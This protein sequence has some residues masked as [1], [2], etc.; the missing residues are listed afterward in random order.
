MVPRAGRLRLP[1]KVPAGHLLRLGAD[2]GTGKIEISAQHVHG[3]GT[4]A[5]A[6]IISI[7]LKNNES[8]RIEQTAILCGDGQVIYGTDD[9]EDAIAANS[10]LQDK[11]LELWK[12]SLHPEFEHLDEVIHVRKTLFAENDRGAIQDF[13]SDQLRCIVRDVRERFK[14]SSLN[15]GEDAEYWDNIPLEVQISVPAMWGDLQRGFVRNAAHKAIVEENSESRV[16]L[17][18]EPL[19]VATVYMLNLAKSGSIKEGESLLLVDCGKGTLDIATVRLLHSPS[20]G[21]LMQLQR[22]GPCSGNGA[23]SHMVNTQAWDRI[24]TGKFKEVPDLDNCCAQLGI[25]RREFLRQFSKEIDRIK[26]D[27]IK[28]EIRT[29]QYAIPIT[30]MSSHGQVGRGRLSKL[31]IDLPREAVVSWY[32][33]W[34]DAAVKLVEEHL[35]MHSDGQYRCAILTGGGCMS[36][37]FRRE[38]EA[39]LNSY[40]IEIGRPTPCNSACSQGALLQH[41]FQEDSLPEVSNYYLGTTEEYRWKIHKDA[42]KA[43]FVKPSEYDSNTQV[44]HNRIKKIMTHRKDDPAKSEKV[45]LV[46]LVEVGKAVRIDI[47]LYCSEIE[48]E[49]HSPLHVD[50]GETLQPGIGRYPLV[51]KDIPDLAPYNFVVKDAGNAK[52]TKHFEL[53]TFVQLDCNND[54]VEVTIYAMTSNYR[55]SWEK[56]GMEFDEQL[57][58]FTHTQEVWN[59]SCSHFVRNTTGTGTF[60]PQLTSGSKRKRD[61]PSQPQRRHTARR[62]RTD[63]NY[64]EMQDSEM[65]DSED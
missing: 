59:K 19:C 43:G 22:V 46:Y 48:L 15:A 24:D 12:L 23:G 54:R 64:S 45:A 9:V 17:R 57:V 37:I 3:A 6:E 7:C 28:K 63:V 35:N 2:I 16:E 27:S 52:N 32:K 26:T 31:S 42:K 49:D 51:F 34:T 38:F 36:G 1:K 8:T 47:D 11:V 4:L 5:D 10:N 56:G 44:V 53:R 62:T 39:V 14:D 60:K 50:D 20:A 30:I 33:A 13:M 55:Y 29:S 21:I 41:F 18:E 58:L 61:V 40:N 65:Q 25:T